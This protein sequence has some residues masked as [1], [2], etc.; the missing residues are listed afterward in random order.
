MVDFCLYMITD[1]MQTAG[2]T[3]PAVVAEALRG[4]LRAVQL[5]EKDLHAGNLF[6]LAAELRQLTKKFGAK[7]LI[8]DRI[9]VAL[10][11]AADGVHLGK[12]SLPLPEARRILGTK[13][14]WASNIHPCWYAYA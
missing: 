1:R 8:N 14:D 4:G 13:S 12:G 9:D 2:R 3:L 10:A 7:L 5:R 6:E 11:V